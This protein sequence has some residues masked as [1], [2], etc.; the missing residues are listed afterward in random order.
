M[1]F[2]STS[3]WKQIVIVLFLIILDLFIY[4]LF[5][6]LLM[7]YDDF[8]EESKGEYFSLESMTTSEQIT[9]VGLQFWNVVNTLIVIFILCRTFI[10]RK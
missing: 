9:F 10:K 5:G 8:Y 7:G 3:L 6:F 2:K 1:L 4:I